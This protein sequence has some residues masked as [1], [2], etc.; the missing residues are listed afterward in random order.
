[1]T[2]TAQ[3]RDFVGYGA[4]PPQFTW[5]NGTRLAVNFVVN[6]EEGAER[7]GLDGDPD[8]EH[9]VEAKYDVPDGERELF[10]ESTFEYG[11]RVGIWRLLEGL[12]DHGVVPTVF[13]CGL[14][15]ERNVPVAEAFV[16]R[17]CDIVGHGYRWVPHT[18][19][20]REQ[21][22]RNIT[23]CV[24]SLERLT[25]ATVRGWFTRPPNTANTRSLLAE[26]GLGY[27]AGSVSDDLPYYEPVDG[28]PFLVVPYSLDVNDTKFFKG[29]FFTADD[30]ARYALDCFETLLAES[31]KRPRL[32]SI[33]LHPRIIGRPARMAGLL[34]VLDRIAGHD[35]VWITG[36]D[37]IAN[38]WRGAFPAGQP[39]HGRD[40]G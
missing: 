22:K 16:Q 36:R 34:R 8:Q 31:V 15:L 28:S 39:D 10:A 18:G 5:P 21:E 35:G 2:A 40:E 32:M 9:L 17:G 29:Q 14:A 6:Y 37:E 1:M 24:T 26:C 23:D 20:T 33:G 4:N 12:D 30:F 38:F 11:S 27:D 19:M 3:P 7:N 25:G 13:A